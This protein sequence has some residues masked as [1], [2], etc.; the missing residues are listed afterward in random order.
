MRNLIR[1]A[2]YGSCLPR[3]TS[4][5]ILPC[6][7]TLRPVQTWGGTGQRSVCSHMILIAWK[8]LLSQRLLTPLL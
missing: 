1:S 4:L 3:S 7:R 8:A 5:H 2:K 6:C